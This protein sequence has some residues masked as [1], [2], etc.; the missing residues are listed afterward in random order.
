MP[1]PAPKDPALRRRR[2]K[3]V[4]GEWQPT[5]TVGWRF[6]DVP[7]APD[8]LLKPSL[9]A[10]QAWFSAWFASHWTPDDLP[11]LRHLIQLYDAFE[12]GEFQRSAEL[13]MGSDGYGIT[14][15]GQQALHWAPPKADE[16]PKGQEAPIDDSASPYGHLRPLPSPAKARTK[17]S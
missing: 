6:G 7:E 16:A 10:W 4:S 2:N 13:R 3:P 5:K 14:P 1:G 9:A 12:R 8:G 11:G 17:A 15:H